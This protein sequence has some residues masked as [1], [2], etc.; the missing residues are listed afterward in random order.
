MIRQRAPASDP[1]R[2]PL[3]RRRPRL[4]GRA[5]RRTGPRGLGRGARE[6]EGRGLR[7]RGNLRASDVPYFEVAAG[8]RGEDP[9]EKRRQDR[10]LQK[11]IGVKDAEEP[12]A[13][14]ESPTYGTESP[15]EFLDVASSVDSRPRRRGSGPAAEAGPQPACRAL[16]AEGLRHRPARKRNRAPPKSAAPSVARVRFPAPG[17]EDSFAYRFTASVTVHA[18]N[19]AAERLPA[20][21]GTGCLT[22][23]EG[24]RRHPRLRRRPG[25]GHPHRHRHPGAGQ[26]EPRAQPARRPPRARVRTSAIGLRGDDLALLQLEKVQLQLPSFDQI[27]HTASGNSGSQIRPHASGAEPIA[28][29]TIIALNLSVCSAPPSSSWSKA[30]TCSRS[31]GSQVHLELTSVPTWTSPVRRLAVALASPRLSPIVRHATSA[32]ALKASSSS[33]MTRHLQLPDPSSPRRLWS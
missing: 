26:Q 24:L 14:V 15:G 9:Q 8:R 18:P 29:P 11:C 17:I 21:R 31:P 10:E 16:P 19:L 3:G 28:L 25:R 20:G 23:A 13:K 1:C 2:R 27:F 22:D 7:P 32:L 30:I 12:L 6:G 33:G 4:R 5:I